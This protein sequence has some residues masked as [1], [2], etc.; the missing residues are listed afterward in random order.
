MEWCNAQDI[1]T[2]ATTLFPNANFDTS[3][4]ATKGGFNVSSTDIHTTTNG[5]QYWRAFAQAGV[6]ITSG[7][8]DDNHLFIDETY[9]HEG[10][11]EPRQDK[12][13]ETEV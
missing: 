2:W 13:K 8:E 3:V 10:N 5:S 11:D 4:D 9:C 12:E 6:G 7:S 1:G